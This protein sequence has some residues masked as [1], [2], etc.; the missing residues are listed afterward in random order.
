MAVCSHCGRTWLAR[1]PNGNVVTHLPVNSELPVSR[2][3]RGFKRYA[4]PCRN[5]T[6]NENGL[7]WLH[8]RQEVWLSA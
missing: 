7:C 2:R 6:T 4:V 5:H 8:Q 3:C 1:Y